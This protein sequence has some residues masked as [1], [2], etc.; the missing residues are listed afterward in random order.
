[1]SAEI[2]K[3]RGRPKK[4]IVET[5]AAEMPEFIKQTTRGKSTK[6]A[7]A[8]PPKAK[9][10]KA[11]KATTTTTAVPE[12]K[13]SAKDQVATQT[14]SAA[15]IAKPAK[16]QVA[17]QTKSAAPIAKPAK[18]QV[19]TQTKNAASPIAS[20]EPPKVV[21]KTASPKPQVSKPNVKSPKITVATPT[22]T[23]KAIAESKAALAI[24][25]TAK[26]PKTPTT[27]V[28]Q[29]TPASHNASKTTGQT[30]KSPSAP[31]SASIPMR[32]PGS[33]PILSKVH[34][35]SQKNT[36]QP[37]P[38][39]TANPT[40]KSVPTTPTPASKPQTLRPMPTKASKPTTPKPTPTPKVPIADINKE[41]VSK[42]TARAGARRRGSNNLPPKYKSAARKVTMAIVAMPI[43]IVTSYVLYQRL[44][45]KEEKKSLLPLPESAPVFVQKGEDK[46]VLSTPPKKEPELS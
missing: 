5:I 29:T 33:S 39:N 27:A 38:S 10:S 43:A 35:L 36:T 42:I 6:A 21:A 44:Y 14:K 1:M 28:S 40:A 34:Q 2:A 20:K 16:D 25:A 23:E 31:G 19:A 32:T 17:T 22:K 12:L 9:I 8:T 26:T 11:A 46:F 15:P 37:Q 24:K 13:K 4:A 41:I 45:L 30:L 3:K 7:A 18:D